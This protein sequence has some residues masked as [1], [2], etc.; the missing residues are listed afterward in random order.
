MRAIG[1]RVLVSLAVGCALV[2]GGVGAAGAALPVSVTRTSV[3]EASRQTEVA[4]PT[5]IGACTVATDGGSCTV[6]RVPGAP[7]T[8]GLAFGVSRAFVAEQLGI[9]SAPGVAMG[10]ACGSPAA[11]KGW[12]LTMRALGTGWTYRLRTVTTVGGR[13]V[14]DRTS[15]RLHAFDPSPSQASCGE[16]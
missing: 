15:G 4:G 10:I 1:R 7:R 11:E 3:L 5:V 9:D 6:A 2:L 12:R 13:V 8:I 16:G 14:E